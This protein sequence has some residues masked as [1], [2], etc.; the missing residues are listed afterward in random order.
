MFVDLAE[1]HSPTSQEASITGEL[2]FLD[3]TQVCYSYEVNSPNY[4]RSSLCS[5]TLQNT[6]VPEAQSGFP[7]LL[8]S[9]PN[10]KEEK[11]RTDWRGREE[12]EQREDEEEEGQ[13]QQRERSQAVYSTSWHILKAWISLYTFYNFAYRNLPSW[14]LNFNRVAM[15]Y[16]NKKMHE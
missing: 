15:Y 2:L 14:G 8:L 6:T 13:I 4:R 11:E 1:Y 7:L 10:P 12:K 16:P 3:L 5:L 9:S